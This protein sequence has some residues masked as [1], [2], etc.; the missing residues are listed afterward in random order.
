ME[1]SRHD[2]LAKSISNIDT[3]TRFTNWLWL[4]LK[5]SVPSFQI[6]ELRSHGIRDEMAKFIDQHPQLKIE[7]ETNKN[8][9]FISDEYLQWITKDERQIGWIVQR[10]Q[11]KTPIPHMHTLNTLPKYELALALIDFWKIDPQS[12][13]NEILQLE[14][15]WKQQKS[16][17]KIFDW[18]KGSDEQ[19]KLEAAWDI[20]HNKH[21]FLPWILD[22]IQSHQEL[23]IF[24]DALVMGPAEVKLLVEEIKKRWSQN[25]YRE[26]QT[27]KKQYNFILSN[28]AIKRLDK[29]VEKYDLKRTQ[30]L[31]ILLQM[32]EEKGIYIA[33]KLRPLLDV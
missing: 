32:E 18:F 10:L 13:S 9:Y 28:K 31:E 23:V 3:N 12:K 21:K 14:T 19:K 8:Y 33:E 26:K 29:L 4:Y 20:V 15:L 2:Q 6:G 11:Q 30:V 17:D 22:K 27:D 7:I 5:T 1:V 16:N 24:F 25:K